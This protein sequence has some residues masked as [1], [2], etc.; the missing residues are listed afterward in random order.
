MLPPWAPGASDEIASMCG[1]V[2]IVPKNGAQGI[3]QRSLYW[4]PPDSVWW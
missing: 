4:N 2:P 3:S 1:A